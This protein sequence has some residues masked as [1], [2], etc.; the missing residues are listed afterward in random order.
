MSGINLK[1]VKSSGFGKQPTVKKDGYAA[2][3][4]PDSM[5]GTKDGITDQN[6][7]SGPPIAKADRG[8]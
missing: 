1:T 2:G 3:R 5:K 7:Y 4:L 8:G 6:G